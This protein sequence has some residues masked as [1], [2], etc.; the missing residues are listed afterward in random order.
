MDFLSSLTGMVDVEI[1]SADI[2]AALLALSQKGIPLSAVRHRGDLSVVIRIR[3]RDY[4]KVKSLCGKRGDSLRLVS[5]TGAYW[6]LKALAGRWMLLG[7]LLL[8]L[9]LGL[10]LPTRVLFV[11]VEGNTSVPS[12]R[13]LEAAENCGIRFGAS[14]R[15]V[16]SE[17]IKNALLQE[18]SHLQ[19]AGVNTRGCVAVISVR[20]R[21]LTQEPKENAPLGHI[22]AMGDGVITECTA[23][24]GSLLC[25]PGQAVKKGDILISG[26]TDCGL[27]TQICQAEGEVYA[28]TQREIGAVMPSEYLQKRDNGVVKR[29]FSLIIGKKRI[30]LW[31][32]SGIWD[33][34]C[35]RIYAEKYITLPGGFVLPIGWAVDI[36]LESVLQPESCPQE[37]AENLLC[38]FA[39]SYVKQQMM[40]GTVQSET[41]TYRQEA[42]VCRLEGEYICT[43]MIGKLQIEKIGE[44]NG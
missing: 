20:E 23:T 26:Y 1:T 33:T 6:R 41:Q 14:R 9:G 4:R 39:R 34:T 22:I 2:P 25:A 27:L 29:K 28:Q 37:E 35:G 5:R 18:I 43:E 38:E 32:D 11:R 15:Q 19:W 13:I 42:G 30:N 24:K 3:R 7:G 10:F 40:A 44:L 16:R 21:T 12:Q 36:C 17:K 31:K 8:F